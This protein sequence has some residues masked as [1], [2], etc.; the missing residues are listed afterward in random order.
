[1][2][3]QK[4]NQAFERTYGW[5]WLLKLQQEL[6]SNPLDKKKGWSKVL[7]PLADVILTKYKEFLPSLVYP[8]RVG[9]HSNTAFGLIFAYDY[10]KSKEDVSCTCMLLLKQVILGVGETEL[11]DLV[12]FNATNHFHSDKECPLTWEPSGNDFLSPCLQES[13]PS[14]Y[15]IY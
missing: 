5:A 3:A 10:A 4:Y 14:S 12:K 11:L 7:Q 8:I 2:F 6:L 13:I 9:V 1:M 15:S